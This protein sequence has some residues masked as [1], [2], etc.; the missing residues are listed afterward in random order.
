MSNEK[1]ENIVKDDVKT[2]SDEELDILTS[3]LSLTDNEN[4]QIIF[5][6]ENE[7]II[8]ASQLQ[9]NHPEIR[10]CKI[11]KCFSITCGEFYLIE[12]QRTEKSNDFTDTQL[13]GNEDFV[14]ASEITLMAIIEKAKRRKSQ[15]SN[16]IVME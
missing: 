5:V 3:N 14:L 10:F 12:P 13:L 15:E 11:V 2:L 16:G 8:Y 9:W 1:L 4:R 7:A 6:D